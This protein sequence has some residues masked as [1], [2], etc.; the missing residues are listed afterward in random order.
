[1]FRRWRAELRADASDHDAAHAR[2]DGRRDDRPRGAHRRHR[3]HRR[4]RRRRRRRAD[5]DPRPRW[6]SA[7][8][9]ARL[10]AIGAAVVV[11]ARR[12]SSCSAAARWRCSFAAPRPLRARL[13]RLAGGGGNW[14]VRDAVAGRRGRD[15]AARRCWRSRSVDRHRA[16]VGAASCPRTPRRA[17]FERVGQSWARVGRRR[18]TSSSSPRPADHRQGAARAESTVPDGLAR[19]P[20][21]D[22]VVGPGRVRAPPAGARVLPAASCM[23]PPSC[24]R[25]ARRTSAGSQSGL[26]QAGAGASKLRAGLECGR[27]RRRPAPRRAPAAQIGRRPA[28]HR[29]RPGPRAARRRSPPG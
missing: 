8:C 6:A 25:A 9:S 15:G 12:R 20:R 24:S 23:S 21:V 19:D 13:G 22:S 4:A 11:D 29:A 28:P 27:E 3:A 26:G 7:R 16:A 1:M 2:R 18:S 17:G 14:V 5:R 10:L